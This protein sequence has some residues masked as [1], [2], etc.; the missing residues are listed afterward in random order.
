MKIGVM[1]FA[2]LHAVSYVRA[3]QAL[4]GVEVVA[5]DPEHATRPAGE[6]G[7]PELAAELG[8]TYLE[9][10]ATLLASGVDGVV[11]CSE[12]ARH[13]P[14]VEQAAAAGVHVLCEK[15]LATTLADGE[16]MVEAC[17]RAGVHL[18]VAY[19]VRFST[20]F[21]ALREAVASGS[22]GR[23][24]SVTGTNN[25][26]LPTG[27]RAWFTDPELAGGGAMV[28][29]TVHVAD[30]LDALLDGV[31]PR[32][33]YAQ[34]NSL[35]HPEQAP[36]ETA[37]LVCVEYPGPVVATID[38]SWSK[39]DSYPTWGGL[40]LEL[41][42]TAGVAHMDAFAQRVDGWSETR[43]TAV[44]QPY[45]SDADAP[46]VAEFVDAIRTGRT[47]QPDGAAGLRS[48]Q[49]V[50]AAQ[51]SARTGDVVQLS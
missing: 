41:V 4:D 21:A 24:C 27:S 48:L 5:T 3:L 6:V 10:Y 14:L 38:C 34:S 12:N 7:G 17:A 1:S 29:H 25:G 39:P 32:S 45:G 50:A 30:L 23:V 43:R 37:G 16:A 28:D 26:R 11:V 18:M 20:A 51:E 9:D 44:W 2:H 19:P 15:P 31:P 36:T 47:P 49:V 33:V 35:I 46:L 22:L 8:V 40:T 13:R 42:A